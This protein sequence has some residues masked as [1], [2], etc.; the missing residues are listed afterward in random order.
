[1]IYLFAHHEFL[2]QSVAA[3]V[4][5]KKIHYNLNLRNM[6]TIKDLV[7]QMIN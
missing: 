2:E 6:A 1:M 5:L 4:D 7:F 3:H